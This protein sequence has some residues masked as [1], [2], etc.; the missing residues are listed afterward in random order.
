MESPSMPQAE[1]LCRAKLA[2]CRV[3]ALFGGTGLFGHERANFEVFKRIV[4]RGACL[5]LIIGTTYGHQA[6]SAEA[7]RLGLEWTTAPFGYLLGKSM[8]G[9]HFHRLIYNVYGLLATSIIVSRQIHAF[10]PTHIYLTNWRYFFYSAPALLT[11]KTPLMFRAGD[12]LPV[13]TRIHRFVTRLIFSRVSC[14]VS[15]SEFVNCSMVNAGLALAKARVIYNFPPAR[16]EPLGFSPPTKPG[17]AIVILFVGQLSEHKGV[18]VLLEAFHR[19][20]RAGHDVVLW[21]AGTPA[22]Q[23]HSSSLMARITELRLQDKVALLGYVEDVTTLLRCSD[24]HVCPSLFDDPSPNVIM[25]AKAEGV[26][27]VG[28]PTGGIPELINHKV[29]G[30]VCRSSTVEALVE[31][32]SFFLGSADARTSAGEA[33]RQALL[34][35]FGSERFQKEWEDVFADPSQ[36]DKC[37]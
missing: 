14:L 24:I 34:T 18:L 13:R 22:L 4:S 3:L 12:C 17:N 6:V 8:F 15:N 25:E 9:R 32:L 28:F 27:S 11:T 33:A 31:G 37:E 23:G 20:G 19:L 10:A 29:D 35:R 7:D 36:A 1:R 5:R 16:K 30:F 21:Y 26:P 2:H